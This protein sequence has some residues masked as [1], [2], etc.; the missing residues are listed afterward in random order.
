MSDRQPVVLD[1]AVAAIVTRRQRIEEESKRKTKAT[2][3]ERERR[4][5]KVSL[6]FPSAAWR[7][8]VE[9]E[10]E[11]CRI[12]VSDFLTWCVS[13]AMRALEDGEARRPVAEVRYWHR[14]GE[15][16]DLP[17]EPRDTKL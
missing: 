9:A 5:R 4:G 11:R 17:W 16:L 6:T 12:R 3:H 14:A 2:P 13:Y 7:D 1:P 8:A 10:A 15:A